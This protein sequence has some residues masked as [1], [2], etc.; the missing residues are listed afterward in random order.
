[1]VVYTIWLS[2]KPMEGLKVC[3]S[4]IQTGCQISWNTESVE[5]SGR[6]ASQMK[7]AL[8]DKLGTKWKNEFLRVEP[9]D[10]VF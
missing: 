6:N 7:F 5:S 3:K 4:K 2:S 10:I 8:I 1:M 9:W